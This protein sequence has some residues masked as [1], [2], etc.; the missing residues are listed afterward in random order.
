MRRSGLLLFLLA[1]LVLVAARPAAGL[2][3]CPAGCS[4]CAGGNCTRCEAGLFLLTAKSPHACLAACPA[5]YPSKLRS[6]S[7]DTC[8][9]EMIPGCEYLRDTGSDFHCE[10]CFPGAGLRDVFTCVPCEPGCSRCAGPGECTACAPGHFL[11]AGQC[12]ACPAGCSQCQADRCTECPPGEVLSE[13]ACA[14]A[15]PGGSFARAGVCEACQPGCAACTVDACTACAPGR[16]LHAGACVEA[17]PGGFFPLAGACGPC[18]SSC[19]AC[20]S[21]GECTACAAGRLALGKACVEACPAGTFAQAGACV[22]CHGSC[23][24]CAS[25]HAC[26]ACGPGLRFRHPTPGEAS[27]CTATCP[28]GQAAGPARCVLCPRGC[29]DCTADGLD[30]VACAEGLHLAEDGAARRRCL[31]DCPAGSFA[32]RGLICTACHPSCAACRG[33]D[34][35][36]ACRPGGWVFAEPDP[37]AGPGLCTDRCAPGWL[38][39]P[40]PAGRGR[41]RPCAPECD[42]CEGAADRCTRCAAGAGPATDAGLPGPCAACAAGCASCSAEGRCLA[43]REGLWLTGTGACVGA[44]PAGWFADPAPGAGECL[45][46]AP[47]CAACHGPRADQCHSCAPGLDHIGSS[48]V[49]PCPAGAFRPAD[50]P[51]AACQPCHVS[52]AVC[53]GPTDSHC[54]DCAGAEL[55][56]QGGRCVQLCAG[57]FTP[58]AG[59]CRACHFTCATCDGTRAGECLDCRPGLVSVFG[60]A[61]PDTDHLGR[62]RPRRRRRCDAQ[63]PT[64]WALDRAAGQAVCMPCPEGCLLCGGGGGGGGACE[65]C[66]RGWLLVPA[67]GQCA[68]ACPAGMA[69]VGAACVPCHGDCSACFGPGA[70]HCISCAAEAGQRLLLGGVC[71]PVGAGCPEG[72]YADRA[73]GACQPCPSDCR[74]CS[75]ADQCTGCRPGVPLYQGRC[76]AAACPAGTFAD[77]APH[78]GDMPGDEPAARCAACHASCARC[79]GPLPGDCLRCP[80]DRLLAPDGRCVEECPPGT[81]AGPGRAACIP[82]PAGCTDCQAPSP[83]PEPADLRCT[84]CLPGLHLTMAGGC[85]PLCP[86]GEFAPRPGADPAAPAP[87]LAPA[88]GQVPPSDP[89]PG[90]RCAPCAAACQTCAHQAAQCTGCRHPAEWLLLLGDRGARCLAGASCPGRDFVPGATPEGDRLCIPCAEAGCADCSRDPAAGPVSCTRAP[91]GSSS[92]PSCPAAVG[93]RRCREGL[94]LLAPAGQPARCLDACPEGHF[95]GATDCRPCARGCIRCDGPDDGHCLEQAADPNG[96]HGARRRAL[97]IGLGVGL[98]MLLLLV[99]LLATGMAFCRRRRR[100]G[101][102]A[103]K[104]MLDENAT[105]LNTIVEISLPGRALV[106]LEADLAPTDQSLGKGKQ[107]TVYA[108]RPVGAGL[109]DRLACPDLVAVKLFHDNRSPGTGG[110][111]LFHSEVALLW[112]LRGCEHVVQMYAYSESPPAIVLELFQT[113]LDRLLQATEVDLP[114]GQRLGLM[115]DIAAGLGA[116][117]AQGVAHC[118]VKAANVLARRLPDGRWYPA[119]CDLGGA[120]NTS[121]LRASAL[122]SEAANVDLLSIAYASPERLE[123]IFRRQQM[124]PVQY[125]PADI[126]ALAVTSW[127]ILTRLPPS[128]VNKGLPLAKL[129][130]EIVAGYRPP[131]DRLREG[132]FGPGVEAPLAALLQDAWAGEASDRPT[133]AGFHDRTV[134]IIL[135]QGAPPV[136]Q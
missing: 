60:P 112:M 27:L 50:N 81:G 97:A 115:R 119:L 23:A 7:V 68:G 20:L 108:A 19:A 30:C 106:S 54:W 17:C 75:Q 1:L 135:A 56:Q 43:C 123:S 49:W 122:V 15:C 66:Q 118:D 3:G 124:P 113:P 14:A 73:T 16:L 10:A 91:A 100:R 35:C 74:A 127:S 37:A 92:P 40:E 102:L 87:A 47:E 32:D 76:L 90:Q 109:R 12:A 88:P 39:V 33:P 46:C 85:A 25:G 83:G 94:L 29:T 103:K 59:R 8:I 130:R 31:P 28:P 95:P 57:G 99:L 133:A 6:G 63:C 36:D 126:Y 78:P 111:S 120:K 69:P 26:L 79:G 107:A 84:R 64:G 62:P 110:K 38:A 52:C 86:P 125:L 129:A 51:A 9:V 53:N 136:P 128:A 70:G 116:M 45:P 96:R 67:S 2:A 93:C 21:E 41:C 34:A 114:P 42:L 72:L 101:P 11:A 117:H 105:V 18:D 98:P 77:M 4:A 104:D 22:A 131:V 65:Q 89:G 44:C 55:V 80:A 5:D 61:G 58:E 71:L 134:A 24:T 121:D 13:G 82:C 48:C 132:H